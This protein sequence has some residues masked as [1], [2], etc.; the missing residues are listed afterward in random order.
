M[1]TWCHENNFST[2]MMMQL[3]ENFSVVISSTNQEIQYQ[4]HLSKEFSNDKSN[5]VRPGI[6][7]KNAIS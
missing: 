6:L 5:H 3:T 7:I 4:M 1:T 2:K